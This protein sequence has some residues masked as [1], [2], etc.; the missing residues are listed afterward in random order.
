MIKLGIT[1][2]IGSGKTTISQFFNLLKI[3]VYNSDL[4]AKILMNNSEEIKESMYNIFGENIYSSDGILNRKEL[5][6]LV[7]S[8]K[9]LLQELNN[10]V[11]PVVKN[12]FLQWTKKFNSKYVIQESA[13][14]IDSGFYKMMDKVLTVTAPIDC[15]IKRVM[16]RDNCTE[17]EVISRMNNQISDK[18]MFKFSDFII[19]NDDKNLII[20]KILEIDKKISNG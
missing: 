7:F 10:I 4:R 14:L 8:S 2:G 19:Q 18:E 1:G 6:K 12:D 5:S 15:K 16:A 17:N 11:H 13:I 9:D 20:L 3:P